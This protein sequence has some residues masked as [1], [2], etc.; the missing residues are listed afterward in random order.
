MPYIGALA[1]P[2]PK[3]SP[4]CLTQDGTLE[5]LAPGHAQS[6]Y[7]QL[8]LDIERRLNRV[9][10]GN[11]MF[12]LPAP[13]EQANMRATTELEKYLTPFCSTAARIEAHQLVTARLPTLN[14]EPVS[15]THLT[16][17]TILLV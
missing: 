10:K 6:Q 3:A 13:I 9:G 16:L 14:A 17:P 8:L 1:M 7:N 12:E 2:S 4:G 15:Y 5:S 11:E